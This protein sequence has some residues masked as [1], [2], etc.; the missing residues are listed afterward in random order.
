MKHKTTQQ[1]KC[2]TPSPHSFSMKKSCTQKVALVAVGGESPVSHTTQ[3]QA[4]LTIT[5]NI[6]TCMSQVQI[7][8]YF[9]SLQQRQASRRFGS[10]APERC[11]LEIKA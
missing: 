8:V 11:H 9:Y 6:A 3:T 2:L 1:Q 7:F 10:R 5:C 4:T